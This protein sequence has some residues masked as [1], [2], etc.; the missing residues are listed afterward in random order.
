MTDL[1]LRD[2]LAAGAQVLFRQLD[3]EAVLL[4][5]KS[6]KYFGLND[7]GARMWQLIIEHGGLSRVCDVLVQEYSTDRSV[8]EHDLL[9]LAAEL[10]TR[11]LVDVTTADESRAASGKA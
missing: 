2:S 4:D 7:L 6:G 9:E 5:L 11:G 1:S 8:I 10:L 3:D